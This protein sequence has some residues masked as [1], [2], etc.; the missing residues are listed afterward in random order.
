MEQGERYRAAVAL[1][2]DEWYK[3][4]GCDR[5]EVSGQ[6]VPKGSGPDEQQ[7]AR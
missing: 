4:T 5:P 1:G 6:V 3:K 2:V 7:E